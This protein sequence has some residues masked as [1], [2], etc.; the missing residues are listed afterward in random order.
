MHPWP[1]VP[2]A[3]SRSRARRAR[4]ADTPSP[5][6]VRQK[7]LAGIQCLPR[8]RTPASQWPAQAREAPAGL[9]RTA[10]QPRVSNRPPSPR[11]ARARIRWPPLR[12]DRPTAYRGLLGPRTQIIAAGRFGWNSRQLP[13]AAAFLEPGPGRSG[14]T[15]SRGRSGGR[16][17]AGISGRKS[18]DR[19]NRLWPTAPTTTRQQ[20]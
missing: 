11:P 5:S 13:A 6:P 2:T 8:Q 12:C 20:Q 18:G 1:R 15:S 9:P 7:H 3:R 4:R 10:A 14:P 19:E 16:S 17:R